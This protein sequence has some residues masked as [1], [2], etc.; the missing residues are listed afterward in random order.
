MGKSPPIVYMD[1]SLS[2][3]VENYCPKGTSP[4]P[5]TKYDLSRFSGL[6]EEAMAFVTDGKYEI[7]EDESSEEEEQQPPDSTEETGQGQ[8]TESATDGTL[9]ADLGINE[10]AFSAMSVKEKRE[11]LMKELPSYILKT[12]PDKL[13]ALLTL[14]K[15]SDE[16]VAQLAQ[17]TTLQE[18][19]KGSAVD[20]PSENKSPYS[21][22]KLKYGGDSHGS[23]EVKTYL[24]QL[25]S[26]TKLNTITGTTA[27]AFGS[28]ICF[29]HGLL[30]SL[31]H[32]VEFIQW[33]SNSGAIPINRSDQLP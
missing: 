33:K 5:P 29:T 19:L 32:T 27:E 16:E 2:G 3:W 21:K 26:S 15:L 23:N 22:S 11:V 9:V 14:S 6:T 13:N 4:N 8:K 30:L 10:E 17:A 18:F 25:K 12:A 24:I 31:G 1:G 28:F 20:P 7:S